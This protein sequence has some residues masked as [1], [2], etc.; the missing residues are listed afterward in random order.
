MSYISSLPVFNLVIGFVI[1][2]SVLF[3]PVSAYSQVKQTL[4]PEFSGLSIT[5]RALSKEFEFTFDSNT[6]GTSQSFVLDKIGLI[7]HLTPSPKIKDKNTKLR[8]FSS[9]GT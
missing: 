3:F 2:L 4:P 1:S 7:L 9:N 5:G 8:V 6:I